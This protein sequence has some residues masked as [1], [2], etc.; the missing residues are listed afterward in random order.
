MQTGH[1]PVMLEE[2]MNFL[3]PKA[4]GQYVDGTLGGGGHTE[5]LLERSYPGGR[6]LGIDS[7]VQALERFVLRLR[8][9]KKQRTSIVG[10]AESRGALSRLSHSQRRGGYGS[11]GRKAGHD[12][13]SEQRSHT[14]R[15]WR[16]LN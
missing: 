3:Q 14:C 9:E 13:A 15:A 2:V 11:L 7:D 10:N 1:I 4:N 6:V 16:S 5:T 8:R 12:N